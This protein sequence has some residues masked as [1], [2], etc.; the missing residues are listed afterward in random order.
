MAN[1]RYKMTSEE[2]LKSSVFFIEATSFEQFSLW[3]EYHDKIP[4]KEDPLGF[5][6]IIGHL[7]KKR[8]VNVSFT[9]AEI[10]G[11]RICFYEAVSRFVDHTMIENFLD[12]NYPVKYSNG[13]RIARTDADNFHLAIDACEK[14]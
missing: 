13:T 14:L 6:Q 2:K 7:S 8:P 1:E 9:F 4:W 3:K 12:T 10:F 5:S 11:K